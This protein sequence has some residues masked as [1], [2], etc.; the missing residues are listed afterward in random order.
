MSLF[1][2]GQVLGKDPVKEMQRQR[3]GSRG[4]ISRH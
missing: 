3:K 1:L 4:K 2:A